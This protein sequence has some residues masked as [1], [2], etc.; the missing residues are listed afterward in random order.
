[1]PKE[2]EAKEK[3]VV[4]APTVIKKQEAKKVVNH[5]FE[6]RSKNFGVG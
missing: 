2:K 6:K 3:K 1:M 4:P 5:L